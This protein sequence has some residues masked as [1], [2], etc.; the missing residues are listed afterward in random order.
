VTTGFQI[1]VTDTPAGQT[2]TDSTTSVVATAVAAPLT[3]SGTQ[4]NQPVNDNATI[5][6]FAHVMIADP[7][8]GQSETVTISFTGA[9]GTLTDPNAAS[10]QFRVIGNGIYSVTDTAAQ[11]STDIDA[12]VFTP[13]LHQVAPGQAVTTGFQITVTDTPAGQTA[14]DSTTSVVATA[15][16]PP[17]VVPDRAGV[18]VGA[19]VTG[20]ILANDKDPIAGDT[21]HVSAVNGQPPVND[22]F[23]VAGTFGT[24]TVNADNGK[25][26]LLRAQQR[27][28]AEQ[29]RC[30]RRVHLYGHH[31]PGR[32]CIVNADRGCDSGRHRDIYRCA[33]WRLGHSK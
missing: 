33:S 23:V 14:T 25:L 27:R 6:P 26:H 28:P 7:N 24:L 15:V 10:D 17:T 16:A 21:L 2:A 13:T 3:I 29:R 22:T 31:W 4:P 1:T 30:R 11:I 19:S 5:D 12:L 32:N 8:F 18:N 20:N 9:N